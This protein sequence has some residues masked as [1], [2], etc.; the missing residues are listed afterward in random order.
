MV[1]DLYPEVNFISPTTF[2]VV[3]EDPCLKSILT[4]DPSML[5]PVPYEYI[6]E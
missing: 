2:D 3:L 6:L 1:L 5:D 4:V